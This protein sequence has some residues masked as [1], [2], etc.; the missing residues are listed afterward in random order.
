MARQYIVKRKIGDVAIVAGGFATLDLPRDYDYQA[1]GLRIE[2]SVAVSV[3]AA[4]AVRAEAPLQ[5]VPRIEVIADGKNTL[6]SAPFWAAAFGNV[7]RY[8]GASGARVTTPPSAV[9]VATYAT[10][11]IGIVDF[12]TFQGVRPKD[13]NFRSRGLS[14]FQL[15]LTFGNAVDMFVQGGA[16]VA[17]SGS[18]IVSVW[19]MQEVEATD[20]KGNYA[21][22]PIALKK[23]SYQ[24]GNYASSNANAEILLPAGNSIGKLLLRTEG[25]VTAGEPSAAV[26]NNVQVANGMD[27]RLNMSAKNLR[28]LNNADYG[29]VQLGYYVVDPMKCGGGGNLKL[30]DIWD[31][32]GATQ[33]KA[34][35]DVTGGATV[36]IQAV[37]TEYIL[38]AA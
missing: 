33:P 25:S 23:V 16:T 10:E 6:Y 28:A 13:S 5:I 26:L 31:L 24:E 7:D 38:A 1:I 21:T 17:F 35:L 29:Q 37:T 18:P 36:K 12:Q 4:T 27:V 32:S 14:L 22:N 8:L 34:I 20:D 3:G 2:A 11:G 19:A 30:T 9:A 15:R